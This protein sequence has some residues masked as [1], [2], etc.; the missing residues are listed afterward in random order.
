M[1][2][3]SNLVLTCYMLCVFTQ[4][5]KRR[6][7]VSSSCSSRDS[8]STF[9]SS[10][11]SRSTSLSSVSSA[12]DPHQQSPLTPRSFNL[13]SPSGLH[14]PDDDGFEH[15]LR[16]LRAGL[17]QGEHSWRISTPSPVVLR[18]RQRKEQEQQA[19][20]SSSQEIKT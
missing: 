17:K 11:L 19:M 5:L 4:Q 13:T 9:A 7:H 1:C 10:S 20:A 12:G 8:Q 15:V 6:P 2:I 16:E 3:L 18:Y 14:K